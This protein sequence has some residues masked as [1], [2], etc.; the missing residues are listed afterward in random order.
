MDIRIHARMHMYV[1]VSVCVHAVSDEF[2]FIPVT[3]MQRHKPPHIPYPDKWQEINFTL[4]LLHAHSE[5]F[6]FPINKINL[7]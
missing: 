2:K 6:Q 1:C 5:I 4:H 3:S 7:Y